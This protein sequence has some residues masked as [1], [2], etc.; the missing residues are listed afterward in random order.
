MDT[1]PMKESTLNTLLSAQAETLETL[2]VLSK[3]LSPVS[4]VEPTAEASD[5][6]AQN[7]NR[8]GHIETALNKQF[9]IN[10]F[11]RKLINELAV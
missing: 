7:A 4:N 9:Q 6:L 1:A 2:N 3:R 8:E 5:K 10:S 11:I